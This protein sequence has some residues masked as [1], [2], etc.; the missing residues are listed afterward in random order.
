V[1]AVSGG[2][3][4][5]D[6]DF[7][8][9]Q[10]QS[11][12]FRSAWG[13]LTLAGRLRVGYEQPFGTSETVPDRQ[14]FKLGGPNSV[15]GYD[16]QDIGPGD[17][18]ILGNVETRFPLVWRFSGALFLDGGNAWEDVGDVRWKDFDPTGTKDD[19]E[20]A[21]ETEFRYSAGT[22]LRFATPVGPVR[23]DVARKLKILPVAE[24]EP[25]DEN[26]WDYQISLGH[27]F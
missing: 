26:R 17:F 19:P 13:W 11:D 16:Y 14:R 22:G 4:G 10:G 18:V 27:V 5:G 6:N 12:W 9:V 25:D 7:W 8:K 21:A 20:R 3:L 23:F 2:L 24:G 1:V 15:R